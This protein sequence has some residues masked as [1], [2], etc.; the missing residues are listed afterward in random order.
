LPIDV[1]G[2]RVD[3]KGDAECSNRRFGCA[4]TQSKV[5]EAQPSDQLTHVAHAIPRLSRHAD[6]FVERRCGVVLEHE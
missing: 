2:L 6:Q 1:V 5:V 4:L 3:G